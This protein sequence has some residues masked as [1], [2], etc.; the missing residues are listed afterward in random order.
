MASYKIAWKRSAE[1]EL[2]KLPKVTIFQLWDRV[3]KLSNDPDP[4][5]A[6]KLVNTE[7]VYR[8]RV[9]DYRLIYWVDREKLGGSEFHDSFFDCLCHLI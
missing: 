8:L 9:G 3:S 7:S 6:K 2:R 4:P 5:G 1:K